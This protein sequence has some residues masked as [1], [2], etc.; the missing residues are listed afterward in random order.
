MKGRGRS[1]ETKELNVVVIQGRGGAGGTHGS[2]EDGGGKNCSNSRDVLR[3]SKQGLFMDQ[4]WGGGGR[5]RITPKCL[6]WAGRSLEPPLTE[7][8]KATE[9]EGLR[10]CQ[11]LRY[12]RVKLEMPTTYPKADCDRTV[13]RPSLRRARGGQHSW[14]HR[15]RAPQVSWVVRPKAADG[16]TA[17]EQA[18]ALRFD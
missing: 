11:P 15:R 3:T 9:G 18:K 14:N 13:C 1:K 12:E 6:A 16:L 8:R 2:G 10:W 5:S 4:M 17:V 7:M